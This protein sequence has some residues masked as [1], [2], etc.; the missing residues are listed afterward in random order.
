MIRKYGGKGKRCKSPCFAGKKAFLERPARFLE[1]KKRKKQ[2]KKGQPQ[3]HTFWCFDQ[4]RAGRGGGPHSVAKRSL[5]EPSGVPCPRG[6]AWVSKRP[7]HKRQPARERSR[8]RSRPVNKQGTQ[9]RKGQRRKNQ[10]QIK[11]IDVQGSRNGSKEG[12]RLKMAR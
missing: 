8:L 3:T 4:L 2:N 7:E 10:S 9:K 12:E 5:E 6:N 11:K 1:K